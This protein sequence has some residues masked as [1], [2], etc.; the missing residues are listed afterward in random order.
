MNWYEVANSTVKIAESPAIRHKHLIVRAEIESGPKTAEDVVSWFK[1]LAEKIDM[2]ILSGPHVE[3]VN[4]V[5]NKGFTSVAIIKTSHI[6]MHIWDEQSPALVQL[7]VYSCKNFNP[8]DVFDHF[9]QFDPTVIS[10]KF[11]DR[12]HGM[13]E[14]NLGWNFKRG[15]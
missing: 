12:E 4:D 8:K 13:H 9:K 5:G 11:L 1:A 7:D 15:D 10:Y 3:Y 2:E 6:S 14:I